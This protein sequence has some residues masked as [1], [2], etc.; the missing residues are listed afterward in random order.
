MAFSEVE[1]SAQVLSCLLNLQG[2]LTE[3]EGLVKLTSLY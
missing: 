3:G 1:N 2:S